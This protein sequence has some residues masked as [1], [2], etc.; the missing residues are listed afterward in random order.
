MFGLQWD[1]VLK[2]LETKG[3][4]DGKSLE[5]MQTELR[6][7]STD[8]GNYQNTI[9]SIQNTLAKYSLDNGLTWKYAPYAKTATGSVLLTTGANDNFYKMNIYDLAGNVWEWTLENS[10][11]AY[12]GGA[13]SEFGFF[14]AA[15]RNEDQSTAIPQVPEIV[16]G[17]QI[18][19]STNEPR[20]GFRVTI[21]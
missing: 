9:F 4:E 16:N 3:I 13:C 21:F 11:H 18:N 12:R 19:T 14:S 2:Y 15:V 1:L 17:V 5:A 10:S 20:A 8:W 7:N 6:A